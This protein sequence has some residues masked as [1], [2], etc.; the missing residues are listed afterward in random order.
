M[1]PDEEVDQVDDISSVVED[2]PHLAGH[3]PEDRARDDEEDIVEDGNSNHLAEN[4]NYLLQE[5]INKLTESYREPLVVKLL[6]RVK[7]QV[8]SEE[9]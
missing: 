6:F 4:R 3:H 5:L 7:H 1:T 2:H 9:T 8:S